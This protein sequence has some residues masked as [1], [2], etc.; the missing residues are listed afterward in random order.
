MKYQVLKV[1]A[2][3]AISISKANVN[4]ACVFWGYQPQMPQGLSKLKK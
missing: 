2:N 1:V 4:S 3:T